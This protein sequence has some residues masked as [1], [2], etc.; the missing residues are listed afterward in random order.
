MDNKLDRRVKQEDYGRHHKVKSY[1]HT[2]LKLFKKH[3]QTFLTGILLFVLLVLLFAISIQLQAPVTDNPPPGVTVVS[4]D[5]FVDQVKAGNIRTVTIQGNELTGVLAHSIRGTACVAH[6]AVT[7]NNPFS[8]ATSSPPIDPCTIYTRSPASSD[9]TLMPLLHSRG[10]VITTLPAR[11]SPVWLNLLWKVAPILLFLFLLLS[12]PPRKGMFSLHTMDNKITQFAKSRAR[13]FERAPEQRNPQPV[14]WPVQPFQ[15]PQPADPRKRPQPAVTFA[16]VAG[17][18]EIRAELEEV[19]QFLRSPEGFH[20]LGAHIPR[21]ILLVGPPGTGKTLLAK[22]VAGEARVPFFSMSASEFVEMFVG[23][24]ASRVR[25]LFQQARQSAPCVIFID[26]IDAV[27]RKRSLSLNTSGERDQT[28]NQLLV[29]LDGFDSCN[30]VVVLA[31]T[32]RADMLDAALL[33][34]GRFDRQLT[35]SL[36]DRRGREAILRVHTRHTPLHARVHLDQLARLTP[37]MSGADLANLVNEAALCAARR[38]LDALTQ[39]CFEEALIRVQLGARRPLVLS[40]TERRMIAT[41]ESGHALV[42][43]YLPAA[44]TVNRIT[45][46]PHGQRLGATLFTAEEDRYNYSRETLL[47]RIAVELGGRV[48]EELTFGSEG[49]RTDAEDDLQAATALAWRMVT[50]WGMGKQVGTVFADDCEANRIGLHSHAHALPVP[51]RRLAPAAASSLPLNNM[52]R[53]AHQQV[54][55]MTTSAAR[56]VSS[57]AMATLIDSEVQNMLHD[58]WATAYTLLSEHYDQLTKLARAL[59]EHEQLNRAQF[60]AVLQQI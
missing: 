19:V 47:A 50:H 48:A 26:E 22:A 27:G 8:P 13:R 41:H 36:P 3:K 51:P 23:V 37:G 21:G 31:A 25:D 14:S 9:F 16:D 39:A 44:D 18:D 4:Y 2:V 28:L 1:R 55:A 59:M 35:V 43:Y 57:D 53:T 11:Q 29:E 49:V 24:G 7:T 54:Y 42:A 52:K 32:D 33:R 15:P 58:G 45:I 46:L 10:V 60:E 20:R 12:L 40:E 38:N 56:Y 17:I 6:P 30:A 34:P 5:A